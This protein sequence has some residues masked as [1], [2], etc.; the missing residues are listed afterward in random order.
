LIPLNLCQFFLMEIPFINLR[1]ERT[2]GGS[3]K[4]I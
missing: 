1:V 2:L 4:Q 3:E